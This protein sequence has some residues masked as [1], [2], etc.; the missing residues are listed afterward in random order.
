MDLLGKCKESK[1]EIFTVKVVFM[2]NLLI[3]EAQIV[4][5]PRSPCSIKMLL[6]SNPPYCNQKSLGKQRLTSYRSIFLSIRA[7]FSLNW[8]AIDFPNELIDLY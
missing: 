7:F 5:Y 1:I 6:I 3:S 2:I 4:V 8:A